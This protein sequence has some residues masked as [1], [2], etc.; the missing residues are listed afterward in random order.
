MRPTRKKLVK[1]PANWHHIRFKEKCKT[2]FAAIFMFSSFI[3]FYPKLTSDLYQHVSLH[4][5]GLL[6][7]FNTET[8]FR[9]VNRD[10]LYI[11]LTI[12]LPATDA[13]ARRP[14]FSLQPLEKSKLI[15]HEF[16]AFLSHL[17]FLCICL[18]I[19]FQMHS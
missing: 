19:S 14:I 6:D 16:L 3:H 7:I 1:Q 12:W 11:F 4:L 18:K 8:I 9:K 10:L 5:N 17:R 15:K 2:H 13:S